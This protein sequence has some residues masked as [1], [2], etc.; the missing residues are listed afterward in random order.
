[1][2]SEMTDA[3]EALEGPELRDG[4]VFIAWAVTYKK[5]GQPDLRVQ[6]EERAWVKD[7]KIVRLKDNMP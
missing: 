6:G 4:A 3:S 2:S 7:G 5:A 1:M